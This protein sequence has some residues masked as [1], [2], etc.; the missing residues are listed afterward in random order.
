MN[1]STGAWPLICKQRRQR[2]RER[3]VTHTHLKT[4][5]AE[6]LNK[7]KEKEREEGSHTHRRLC[8]TLGLTTTTA[9]YCTYISVYAHCAPLGLTTNFLAL[10]FITVVEFFHRTFIWHCVLASH[11]LWPN[12]PSGGNKAR[13]YIGPTL[14]FVIIII[15]IVI[16][17][18]IMKSSSSSS[19]NHQNHRWTYIDV[20]VII[21][22]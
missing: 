22:V 1:E 10:T 16:I 2:E 6:K 15:L 4:H 21:L 11:P 5:S 19:W 7:Y 12:C 3:R 18:S 17:I 9:A 20:I 14:Q 8:S 13:I